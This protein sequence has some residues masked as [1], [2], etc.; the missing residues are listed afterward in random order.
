MLKIDEGFLRKQRFGSNRVSQAVLKFIGSLRDIHHQRVYIKT[1]FL[2]FSIWLMIY[3]NFYCLARVVGA[4]LSFIEVVAVSA[5][6]IPLTMIP[7]QGVAN[8]GAHEIGWVLSLTL[9]GYDKTSAIE[10]AF[11]THVLLLMHVLVFGFVGAA[12][13]LGSRRIGSIASDY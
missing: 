2:S 6:L 7:V 10:V 9:F 8:F 1:A 4:D 5:V 3:S 11:M 12:L 13:V